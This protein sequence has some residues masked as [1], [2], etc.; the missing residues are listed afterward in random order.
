MMK[1]III[2]GTHQSSN[3]K[4]QPYQSPCHCVERQIVIRHAYERTACTV[5]N[6]D[7]N[8]SHTFKR[9]MY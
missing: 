8:V 4:R 3:D 2:C 9:I 6:D 7:Q 1:T 5:C